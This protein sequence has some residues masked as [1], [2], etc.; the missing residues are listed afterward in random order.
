MEFPWCL[1]KV[2]RVLQKSFQ[3]GSLRGVLKAFQ[4]YLKAV[5]LEFLE[6]FNEVP[7]CFMKLSRVYQRKVIEV[8]G[9]F[10]GVSKNLRGVLGK[11]HGCHR[12]VSGVFHG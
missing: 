5:S 6:G 11:F 4:W 3:C 9:N 1:K 10:K 2:S 8:Y 7:G 12:E